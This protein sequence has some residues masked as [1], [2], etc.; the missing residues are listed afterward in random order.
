MKTC[1]S[2]GSELQG[3]RTRWCNL[4][5]KREFDTRVRIENDTTVYLRRCTKCG[6]EKNLNDFYLTPTGTYRRSCKSCTMAS[7]DA[8][9]SKDAGL[10]RRTYHL[11]SLYGLEVAQYDAMFLAQA[12]RCAICNRPPGKTRL[13]VDHDHATGL[14]RGL[15]CNHCNLRI[16]GRHTDAEKLMNAARYLQSPPAIPVIGQHT[17][18]SGRK[19]KKKQPRKRPRK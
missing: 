15:L 8:R 17:V 10:V 18:P 4:S 6:L 13:S 19:P 1:D 5:C 2:C 11:K 3:R 9:N 12:G 16:V 14:I 7:N